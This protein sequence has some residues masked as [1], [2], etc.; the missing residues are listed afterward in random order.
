MSAAS[1]R[2][3]KRQALERGDVG[4]VR[5]QLQI[6]TGKTFDDVTCEDVF[7]RARYLALD[8]SEAK[9][10]ES[11]NWLAARGASCDGHPV[12]ANDPLPTKFGGI[13]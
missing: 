3:K 4:F 7:H 10:R 13:N 5:S 2:R 1:Y 12:R 6:E 8:V 9:R 11:Q